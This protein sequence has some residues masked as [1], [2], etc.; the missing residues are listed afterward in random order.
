[1]SKTKTLSSDRPPSVPMVVQTDGERE[2]CT[3]ATNGFD[4]I[5]EASPFVLRGGVAKRWSIGAACISCALVPASSSRDRFT[6]PDRNTRWRMVTGYSL[7]NTGVC[8]RMHK[9]TECYAADSQS[10]G[11]DIQGERR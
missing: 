3:G 8:F 4:G 6:Q 5:S 9:V 7:P 11:E 2:F 10:G 1:M